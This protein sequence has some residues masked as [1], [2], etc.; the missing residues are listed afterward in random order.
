[1]KWF[2]NLKIARKLIVGFLVIAIIAAAVGGLG[3]INILKIKNADTN[4]YEMDA[5][6]LQY[7]GSASV[8]FMQLR[9][10]LFKQTALD[11]TEDILD[12]WAS[13][14]EFNNAT[15]VNMD[16]LIEITFADEEI[17]IL[18]DKIEAG[19]AEYAAEADTVKGLNENGQI[20]EAYD[21]ILSK[22]A[23]LGMDLRDDF[24]QLMALV[25]TE[26][27]TTASDNQTEAMNTVILML[28]V[29]VISIIVSI[30]LAMYISK[31]ISN[32][33]QV[34]SKVAQMLSEGD[35]DIHR[36]LTKKDELLKLRKD[37]I[38]DLTR[39]FDALIENT[40]V[41]VEATRAI[42]DGDLSKDIS[43]R[44]ERDVLG[45]ALQELTEKFNNLATSIVTAANEVASGSSMVSNS[46]MT[47]SQGTTE[48][49]SAIQQLTASIEEIASQTTNSASNAGKVD[50]IS[51]HAKENAAGGNDRMR[52]MLTA[53]EDINE[54]SSKINKIIKVIDDIAF[55]TN[56][57]AL[58]AAVEAARAGQHGKGFAVVAEEVRTLAGRSANAAKETTDLI[59]NSIQKV[60]NGTKIANETADAL[61]SIVTEVDQVADLIATI[62]KASEE[63]AVSLEQ[64]NIGVS[65]VSEVIQTNAATAEES[66][67]ASEE[68]SAQA[69]HLKQT[70]SV[71]KIKE[72]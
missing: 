32:P 17:N 48:Q 9:Y 40:V 71:F 31:Q 34:M 46:S 23:P 51:R 52:D 19:V 53:M 55:Q 25:A 8:N 18:L 21:L 59:E 1:M 63:Q 14:E 11:N 56:I 36:I 6:G 37:E 24:L 39:A 57:L 50:E 61:N 67:A 45:I 72:V 2:E 10:F 41:Q 60:E 42:A 20:Q 65:Q 16:K 38:G 28:I 43:I 12:N 7:S 27:E 15:Q 58:N 62:R 70:V 47:L 35:V 13:V 33:L 64:I 68:L 30:A 69:E 29:V 49:A 26:A 3:I 22:M 44:S 54:S 66:A 5:L 4:L